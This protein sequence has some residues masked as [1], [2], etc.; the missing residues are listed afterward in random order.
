MKNGKRLINLTLLSVI[1]FLIVLFGIF[2]NV[3]ESL[4]LAGELA[5]TAV[6]LLVEFKKYRKPLIIPLISYYYIVVSVIQ[7]MMVRLNVVLMIYDHSGYITPEKMLDSELRRQYFV[8]TT[9]Y[10]CIFVVSATIFGYLLQ[11]IWPSLKVESSLKKIA[12]RINVKNIGLVLFYILVLI[13]HLFI[14]I[15]EKKYNILIPGKPPL[16]PH[17][18]LYVYAI[19]SLSLFCWA[20][21]IQFV[22]WSSN[23]KVIKAILFFALGCVVSIPGIFNGSRGGIVIFFANAVLII[24]FY[25]GE[26]LSLN[27]K[28]IAIGILVLSALAIIFVCA[29]GIREKSISIEHVTIYLLNRFTGYTD[30][31]KIIDY[32]NGGGEHLGVSQFFEASVG[33][34][35]AMPASIYYT[36]Q[37]MG[38]TKGNHA[39]ATPGFGTG[40]IYAGMLGVIVVSVVTAVLV[41]VCEHLIRL[42]LSKSWKESIVVIEIYIFVEIIM[43]FIME[44][45]VEVLFGYVMVSVVSL[46]GVWLIDR[47]GVL[48]KISE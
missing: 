24:Y 23:R 45:T 4:V 34:D 37:I 17:S 43:N 6:V 12:F 48:R 22:I 40:Y 25:F 36:I 26:L 41:C 46:I 13:L 2:E 32:Y 14:Y 35:S 7:P 21:G 47:I 8:V 11:R 18:G 31:L 44:G 27:K 20:L 16:L 5:L 9:L 15:F 10:Y 28:N 19:R 1:L 38:Y 3:S 33:I 29:D 30:A 42:G 39:W